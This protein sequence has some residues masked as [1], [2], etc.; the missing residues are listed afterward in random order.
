MVPQ[1]IVSSQTDSDG[2][3][4]QAAFSFADITSRY[5]ST[6]ASM[7]FA[8]KQRKTKKTFGLL[9]KKDAETDPWE[10]LCIDLIGPYT[11]R[12]PNGQK[13]QLW[14]ITIIDPATRWFEMS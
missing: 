8:S 1:Q 4:N 12:Q 2:S 5:V 11:I 3:N 7:T 9:P 6:V 14:C 10:V 13:L